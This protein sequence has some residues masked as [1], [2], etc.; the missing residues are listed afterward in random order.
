MRL[1]LRLYQYNPLTQKWNKL[2]YRM[3]FLAPKNAK[4]E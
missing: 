1:Y 3:K 4:L 2:V